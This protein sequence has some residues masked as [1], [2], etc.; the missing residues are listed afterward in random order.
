MFKHLEKYTVKHT[1][2][3][4]QDGGFLHATL[5]WDQADPNDGAQFS[6]ATCEKEV[7]SAIL[8]L[9]KAEDVESPAYFFVF[10][11]YLGLSMLVIPRCCI[12]GEAANLTHDTTN[13]S[14]AAASS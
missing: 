14:R 1:A 11:S 9:V 3:H 5:E 4:R 8:H 13:A 2:E 10:S 6:F 12:V 7:R